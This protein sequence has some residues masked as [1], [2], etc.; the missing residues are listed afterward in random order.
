MASRASAL[1]SNA[2]PR[3]TL[4]CRI[5]QTFQVVRATSTPLTFPR[6]WF[7]TVASTWSPASTR[8]WTS[9]R[10]LSSLC[11]GTQAHT[12]SAQSNGLKSGPATMPARNTIALAPEINA[13]RARAVILNP[14]SLACPRARRLDTCR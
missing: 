1:L 6:P 3:M 2:C 12:G 8:S 11:A 5:V 14:R 7:V 13:K 9:T 10:G 4:P